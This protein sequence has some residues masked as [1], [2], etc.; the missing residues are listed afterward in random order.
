MP[1]DGGELTAI[2]ISVVAI[3]TLG[4]VMLLRPLSKRLAELLEVTAR[5]R[6]A[7]FP[8]V[9]ALRDQIET[10]SARLE[11][12]EDRQDFTERLLQ[13]GEPEGGRRT[14]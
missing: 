3:V 11:L 8:E 12:L 4:G 10:L 2:I 14:G 7:G 9:Q 5:E 13:S 1:I 6:K